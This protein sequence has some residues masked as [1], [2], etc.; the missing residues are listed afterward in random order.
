MNLFQTAHWILLKYISS[1]KVTIVD[2]DGNN[3]KDDAD[4]RVFHGRLAWLQV[5]YQEY[6]ASFQEPLFPF[7]STPQNLCVHQQPLPREALCLVLRMGFELE[8]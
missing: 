4:G 8:V 3:A 1:S 7:P 5:G 2:T 6:R